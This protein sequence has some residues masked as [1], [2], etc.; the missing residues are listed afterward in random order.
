MVAT[1]ADMVEAEIEA[2]QQMVAAQ[3]E[4]SQALIPLLRDAV[5]SP[6]QRV[7][8]AER[9]TSSQQPSRSLLFSLAPQ[10]P[11][12]DSFESDFVPL[13]DFERLE[14]FEWDPDCP[15]ASRRAQD[16]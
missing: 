14:E 1:R 15:D 12:E 6:H 8:L 13:E 3:L 10:P 2:Y 4:S 11:A 16:S 5:P 7:R 9:D